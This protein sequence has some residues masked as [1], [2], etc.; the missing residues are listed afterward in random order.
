MALYTI[1]EVAKHTGIS[2]YSLRYYDKIGLLK[3]AIIDDE[4]GY[5]YY[6]YRQFWHAEVITILKR[7][8][9]SNEDIIDILST[10]Y[11][12]DLVGKVEQ[13][14]RAIEEKIR[15]FHQILEDAQWL[16]NELSL[17]SS[18][19]IGEPVTRHIDERRVIY[20]AN[21]KENAEYHIDLQG[22]SW[23]ELYEATSI[24]RKYG[25]LL[26]HS[27]LIARKLMI[28]GGYVNLFTDN[29]PHTEKDHV[30]TIPAGNYYCQVTRI[31]EN[32]LQLSDGISRMLMAGRHPRFVIC[33]EVGL[34]LVN[35]DDFACELQIL[36]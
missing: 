21:T 32:K 7:L 4:N 25:Y 8:D 33:E 24:R 34:P 3:P 10:E 9:F 30:L 28:K 1:N 35:F 23:R 22:A 14:Q 26:E 18:K 15:L 29:Y 6:T 31:V 16:R 17:L 5:R 2:T 11:D 13:Q 12:Q 19:D 36:F 27:S 20:N